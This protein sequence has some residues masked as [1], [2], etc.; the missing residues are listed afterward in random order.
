MMNVHAL[1]N[2]RYMYVGLKES[3]VGSSSLCVLYPSARSFLNKCM[4]IGLVSLDTMVEVLFMSFYIVYVGNC[5]ST[6]WY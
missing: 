3:V 6:D 4:Y 2:S 1:R 5:S